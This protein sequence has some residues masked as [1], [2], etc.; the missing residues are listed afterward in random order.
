MIEIE[1]MMEEKTNI[2]NNIFKEYDKY[3]IK[4]L[5]VPGKNFDKFILLEN[6][7][8]W[9]NKCIGTNKKLFYLTSSSLYIDFEFDNISFLFN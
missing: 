3:D 4:N 5:F 9:I 6:N 7:I 1:K 2:I 8:S